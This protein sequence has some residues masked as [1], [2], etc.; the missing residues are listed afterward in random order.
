MSFV[1]TRPEVLELLPA[2]ADEQSA[3]TA[4]CFI[5]ARLGG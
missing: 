2:P 3:L 5:A 1:I 4:T